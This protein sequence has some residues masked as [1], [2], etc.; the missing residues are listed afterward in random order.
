M[1]GISQHR[2]AS[3]RWPRS[4]ASTRSI[5]ATA[6]SPRTP[7]FARACEDNGITFVGP[8]PELL[9]TFGDKTAAKRWRRRPACRRFRAPSTASP[10]GARSKRRPSEIG[11]PLIIKASFGGGGR[12]MRV[13]HNADELRQARRG[14]ARGRRPHSAGPR[15]RRALHRA[16]QAHRSADS[17]RHPRQPRPPLGARLLGPAPPSESGRNRA[18]HRPA[19][20]L[21]A[22]NLR[23]GRTAVPADRTTATRA[24]SSS[25]S[26]STRGVLLHRGQPAHP[27]RAHGDGSRDR[28]RP[29]PRS[30]GYALFSFVRALA[31][32]RAFTKAAWSS[33]MTRKIVTPGTPSTVMDALLESQASCVRVEQ[34][35][36]L[37]TPLGYLVVSPQPAEE[38]AFSFEFCHDLVQPVRSRVA[39]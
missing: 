32:S 17:R 18:E 25:C 30:A 34:G 7:N 36:L 35:L 10:T 27:G 16:G 8:T 22:A 15:F 38:G 11:Y 12:G 26:T 2:R 14:P 29:G 28:H 20:K 33:G 19:A 24:R 1:R 31:S 9:E 6:F 39:S 23:S 37:G 21:R 5:P 13:V 4:T 3:S